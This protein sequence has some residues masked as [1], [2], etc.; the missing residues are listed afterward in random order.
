MRKP[1]KIAVH[2]IV[3]LVLLGFAGVSQAQLVL[4]D[5]FNGKPIDPAKWFG[6]ERSAGAPAPN[7]EAARK[8][9]G[10]KLSLSATTWGRTDS[11]SGNAGNEFN[12]LLVTNPAP[13]TTIQADVTVKE[14][15]VIGCAVNPTST[16]AR[17]QIAAAFFNDGGSTGP[18]DRT[19]DV[20]ATIQK[21]RDSITGDQMEAVITRCS[22]AACTATNALGFRGFTTPW[23]AG[24]ADTLTLQWDQPNHQ[25]VYTVAHKK[26]NEVIT[27]AYANP[28]FN[29]PVLNFK[30]LAANNSVASCLAPASRTS[31][32]MEAHFN[33]VMVNP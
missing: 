29:G 12:A 6:S 21:T 11:N 28:D 7:T 1:I 33:N 32:T 13:I 23:T 8:I 19:G 30:Q 4:Y 5:D 25:F 9:A 15:E 14:V 31:A 27:L 22:N 16:R 26:A 18:A 17:A 3:P 20:F 2:L 10:N 24:D